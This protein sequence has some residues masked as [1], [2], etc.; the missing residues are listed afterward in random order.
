MLQDRG[1]HKAGDIRNPADQNRDA[2]MAEPEDLPDERRPS[3]PD[4]V[5]DV[6]STGLPTPQSDYARAE[7]AVFYLGLL[8]LTEVVTISVDPVWGIAGFA[9]LVVGLMVGALRTAKPSGLT[10]EGVGLIERRETSLRVALLLPPLIGIAALTLPLQRFGELGRSGAVALPALVAAFAT[11]RA[12]GYRRR[13]AGVSL[14][15]CWRSGLFNLIVAASGI[16]F[17]YLRFRTSESGS[18]PPESVSVAFLL[19]AILL[20]VGTGFTNEFVYRGIL[21]RAATDLFGPLAGVVYVA[22]LSTVPIIGQRSPLDTGLI[23]LVAVAFGTVVQLTR[24][25]LGVSVAHAIAIVCALVVFPA[26]LGS[27]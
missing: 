7:L 16:G 18:S 27:G 23:F 6:R 5:L 10:P 4:A 25:I 26:I 15:R 14:P 9:V 22:T 8:T 17:G 3:E 1:P 11:M 13:D 20:A 21:Q 12:N 24:S 19:A 2:K